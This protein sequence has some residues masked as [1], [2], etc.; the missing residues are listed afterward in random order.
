MLTGKQT[1]A[2]QQTYKSGDA[3]LMNA[4]V[5]SFKDM[6]ATV[7]ANQKRTPVKGFRPQMATR[8]HLPS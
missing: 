7:P 2:K 5:T 6:L 4:L 8:T 3:V 1:V